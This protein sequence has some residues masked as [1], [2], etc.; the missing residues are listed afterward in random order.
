M[1]R[2]VRLLLSPLAL[3]ATLLLSP[4]AARAQDAGTSAAL[5]V[6]GGDGGDAGATP[7]D[8]AVEADSGGLS[9][10]PFGAAEVVYAYNLGEPSNGLSASRLN[11]G[12][13]ATFAVSNLVVGLD[14]AWSIFT[15]HLAFQVGEMPDLYYS[16][17]DASRWRNVQEVR[18][19]IA[20][21]RFGIDCGIY[22]SPVGPESMTTSGG[23]N[24]LP[25]QLSPGTV[26]P[27]ISN[28][29]ISR[30]FEFVGLPFYHAGCRG[31]VNLG[32]GFTL[33][34]WLVNGWNN[35]ADT[36]STP[37]GILNLQ[38]GWRRFSGSLLTMIGNER[39]T[40]AAEGKPV[41]VLF[42]A[43]AQW[44]P[45]D[46]LS[47]VGQIDG[48][49]EETRFG[50][51]GWFATSLATRV[52]FHRRFYLAARGGFFREWAGGNSEGIAARIFWPVDW[53]ASGTFT[54]AWRPH[55]NLLFRAEYR[56]DEASGDF[57]YAGQV[58]G[59]GSTSNPFIANARRQDTLTLA[60]TAWF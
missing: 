18:A 43:W 27:N 45:T 55:D 30:P 23:N 59:D 35:A 4:L 3:A 57:F 54:A 32:R 28:A 41:R 11:D 34:G 26:S 22:L 33:Y 42:D 8:A 46:T 9:V 48:G 53:V 17:P 37:T 7:A 50:R 58:M 15:A 20:V 60:L 1:I 24:T 6:A 40:G 47:F 29:A 14:A 13:H 39:A 21:D 31:T 16:P 44:H 25:G 51:S 2:T 56:H 49:F 19:G 5:V 38:V 52:H 36:N 12:R 10:T